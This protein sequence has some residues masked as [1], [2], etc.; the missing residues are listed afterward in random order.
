M[1]AGE[2]VSE[3][4]AG[5][6]YMPHMITLDN[7]GNVWTT[8]VALHVATKW[9]PAGVKLLE[10][11]TRLQPGHDT[12]HLCKPTQV[13]LRLDPMCFCHSSEPRRFMKWCSCSPLFCGAGRTVGMITQQRCRGQ[14]AACMF[15]SGL[16]ARIAGWRV[17]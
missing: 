10:L 5:D 6:F 2:L 3:W 13:C 9:S 16:V 11:G 14:L 12:T 15:V 7:E 17:E 8:D 1:R 4:G